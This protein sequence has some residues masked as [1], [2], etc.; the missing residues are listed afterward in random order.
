[1]LKELNSCP[2]YE[3]MFKRAERCVKILVLI[4]A[5]G[6]MGNL[7][8]NVQDTIL[9]Y[10]DEVCKSLKTSSYNENLFK[11]QIV[12]YRNYNDGANILK[13][14]P[15]VGPKEKQILKEYV[16]KER[17]SGGT[18]ISANEAMEI[19]FWHA[20]NEIEKPSDGEPVSMIFVIGD[21]PSNTKQ[22]ILRLKYKCPTSVSI[23]MSDDDCKTRYGYNSGWNDSL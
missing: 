6:S 20:N 8:K 10:F 17:A 5:T 13:I 18:N 12:F 7:L 15:W 14:S 22:E 16:D 9:Q 19:A 11:I 2:A 21:I 3:V 4:D 1:M 23:A